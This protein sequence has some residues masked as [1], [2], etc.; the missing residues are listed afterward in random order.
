MWFLVWPPAT[1][2]S[3][4]LTLFLQ[5]RLDGFPNTIPRIH[6]RW[7]FSIQISS[8]QTI[9]QNTSRASLTVRILRYEI[10]KGLR[11]VYKIP[12]IIR[13]VLSKV[14]WIQFIFE[15]NCLFWQHHRLL[16]QRHLKSEGGRLSLNWNS[17]PGSN[18]VTPWDFDKIINKMGCRWLHLVISNKFLW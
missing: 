5:I 1:A 3:E 8:L 2:W 4:S 7:H 17:N 18:A 14:L 15:C 12:Q 6:L 11:A 16:L 9:F 13:R 10:E